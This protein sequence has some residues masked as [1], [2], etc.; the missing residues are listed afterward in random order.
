M[1]GERSLFPPG[2]GVTELDLQ[3]AADAAAGADDRALSVLMPPGGAT[4]GAT[5]KRVIP[6]HD[7]LRPRVS[8]DPIA[9]NPRIL[10]LDAVYLGGSAGRL[11]ILPFAVQITEGSTPPAAQSVELVAVHAAHYDLPALASS[12]LGRV[13]TVYAIVTRYTPGDGVRPRRMKDTTTGVV[14]TS[15][16]SVYDTPR[17][18][19]AVS[20]GTEGSSTPGTVPADGVGTYNV[21]LFEVALPAPYTTGTILV[22]ISGAYTRQRWE[23]V[24]V[25]SRLAGVARAGA[26]SFLANADLG[27]AS[28][29]LVNSSRLRDFAVVRSV[30][31][32]TAANAQVVLDDAVDYR[33]RDVRVTLTRMASNTPVGS[34]GNYPPPGNTVVGGR[35]LVFETGWIHTGPA[36]DRASNAT[37][38]WE[39]SSGTPV[40]RLFANSATN[41]GDPEVGALLLEIDDAPTDGGHGGDYWTAFIEYLSSS[42]E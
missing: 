32:H 14:T 29:E 39:D 31:R 16:Q 4:G 5:V 23:R 18:T 6:L 20:A 1:S 37:A 15:D 42:V 36:G 26:V 3:R 9:N 35:S 33:N 8:G 30:F 34:F 10:G 11:R 7:E 13:D 24:A 12:T 2:L 19:F 40:V 21:K 38:F 22:G 25:P 17:V 27:P 28:A 41:P